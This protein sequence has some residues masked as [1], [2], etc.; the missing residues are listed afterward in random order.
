ME[1]LTGVAQEGSHFRI[2]RGASGGD[3]RLKRRACRAP[4]PTIHR[5]HDIRKGFEREPRIAH[6][7]YGFVIT[8]YFAAVHVD[9]GKHGI[10]GDSVHESVAFWSVRVPTS[11]IKSASSRM[12]R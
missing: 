4:L 12:G 11:R 7:P 8:T 5:F 9:M 2:V 1:R 6:K 3:T 10:G